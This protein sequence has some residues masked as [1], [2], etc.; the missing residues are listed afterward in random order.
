MNSHVSGR[1]RSF[2]ANRSPLGGALLPALAASVLLSSSAAADVTFGAGTL[3]IVTGGSNDFIDIEVGPQPGEVTVLGAGD[4]SGT[5]FSVRGIVL[6]T[7]AGDDRVRID[8]SAVYLPR[9]VVDMGSGDADFTVDFDFEPSPFF[10]QNVASILLQTGNAS[11]DVVIRLDAAEVPTRAVVLA[12]LG[13]GSNDIDVFLSPQTFTPSLDLLLDVT[14][15]SGIDSVFAD[16]GDQTDLALVTLRGDLGGGGDDVDVELMATSSGLNEFVSELD[17]GDGSD[18]FDLLGRR[19]PLI[20][21]GEVLAG[22]GND[23][24]EVRSTSELQGGILLS[25]GSGSDTLE[26]ISTLSNLSA[27]VLDAGTGN[28]DVEVRTLSG[29]SSTPTFS[30]GGPGF[31]EFLGIGQF[32]NFEEIGD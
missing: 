16:V 7:G 25:G 6:L 12:S 4:G 22:S 26:M 3:Q 13:D 23:D 9:L 2:R 27:S 5:Y 11:D 21:V 19:A 18:D 8:G 30:D 15:G 28:D 1:P 31:D 29:S 17:L 32:V 24:L 20:V 14:G 10:P